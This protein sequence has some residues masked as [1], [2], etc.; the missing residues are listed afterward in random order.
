MAV[1]AAVGL[2]ALVLVGVGVVYLVALVRSGTADPLFAALTLVLAV[3]L[4]VGLLA[5][6]RGLLQGRRWARAPVITWQLLQSFALVRPALGE[7]L[8]T[9]LVAGAVVLLA[10]AVVAV[11][12]LFLPPV[13][14]ATSGTQ[15]PPVV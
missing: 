12:G 4:G 8:A 14:R 15:A 13:M 5:C 6:A 11:V 7:G 2:E 3:G 10:A 9:P 1:V